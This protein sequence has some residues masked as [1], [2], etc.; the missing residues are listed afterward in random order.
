MSMKN[1]TDTI[2]KQTRKLPAYSTVPQPTALPRAPYALYNLNN[3]HEYGSMED[4]MEL[5]KTY[6]KGSK[7]NCFLY[8]PTNNGAN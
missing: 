4:P 6:T 1:S 7:M 2:G 5:L 8:K 3:R